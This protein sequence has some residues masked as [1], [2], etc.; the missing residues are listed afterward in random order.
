MNVRRWIAGLALPIV[1]GAA[2]TLL[3]A[4]AQAAPQAG[5]T[6]TLCDNGSF[7][8]YLQWNDLYATPL[9]SPGHCITR[10]P[11]AGVKEVNVLANA[12]TS[13]WY[14]GSFILDSS[15]NVTVTAIDT[16]SGASYYVS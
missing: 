3:P 9:V 13:T 1:A 15:R 6:V 8:V 12:G 14:I 16:A 7:S 5:G 2:V 4:T 11:E 10:W